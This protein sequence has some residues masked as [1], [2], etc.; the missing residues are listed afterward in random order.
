MIDVKTQIRAI[1]TGTVAITNLVPA[2]RILPTWLTDKTAFP[3]IIY[4]YQNGLRQD[5]DYYDN[6]PRS[7]TA[8]VKID[9]FQDANKNNFALESAID[10][11]MIANVWNLESRADIQEATGASHTAMLYSKRLYT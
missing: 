4:T 7:E 6:V 1:L 9:V 10:T 3:C 8:L 2:T 5:P 11:A